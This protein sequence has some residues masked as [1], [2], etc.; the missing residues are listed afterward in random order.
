M[1]NE[2]SLDTV[3][4]ALCHAI[5]IEPPATAEKANAEMCEFIDSALNGKKADRLFMSKS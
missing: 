4:G 1:Y 5:G 2:K 3:C